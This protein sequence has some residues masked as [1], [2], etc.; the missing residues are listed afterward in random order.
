MRPLRFEQP[1]SVGRE[2]LVGREWLF[3]EV[4][5][6][7]KSTR[8]VAIVGDAGFGK[9]TLID[10][11]V[12][13]ATGVKV[14][15]AT[16]Q[17]GDYGHPPARSIS[18]AMLREGGKLSSSMSLHHIPSY[19]FSSPFTVGAQMDPTPAVSRLASTVV[20]YHFCQADNSATCLVPEF[21]RSLA[22]YLA[23][24]PLLKG[25]GSF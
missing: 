5:A 10:E 3:E 8:A 23:L 24:S 25:T 15:P 7:L 12:K 2:E 20:G 16:R 6:R 14:T 1:G 9:T 18:H 19:S 13:Y 22:A 11:L 21:V 4:E 17:P